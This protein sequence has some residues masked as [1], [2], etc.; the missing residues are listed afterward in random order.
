[1]D[2]ENILQIP[3]SL[4]PLEDSWAWHFERSFSVKTAY[5]MI[6]DIKRRCEAWLEERPDSS[7]I[8][9][10]ARSW[11]KLWKVKIPFK[12]RNFAWRRAKQSLPTTELL[13]HRYM[14]SDN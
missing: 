9:E 5:R 3:I 6:I 13:H 4:V 12:V 2:V 10:K 14:A 11:C 7:A 8:K 1:M